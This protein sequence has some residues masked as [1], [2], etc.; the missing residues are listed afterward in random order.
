MGV[1]NLGILFIVFFVDFVEGTV[2]AYLIEPAVQTVEQDGG[3]F[4]YCPRLELGETYIC[5]DIYFRE[6][7]LGKDGYLLVADGIIDISFGYHDGKLF[8]GI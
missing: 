4:A 2:L 7:F 5:L 8:T 6:L 1:L 3:V